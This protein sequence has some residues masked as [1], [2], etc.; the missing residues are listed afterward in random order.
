MNKL[1]CFHQDNP[2]EG[3]P[4]GFLRGLSTARLGG[5]AQ[6]I[7][8]KPKMLEQISDGNS[9]D[10]IFYLDGAHSPESMEVC[11]RWFSS[12]VG[13]A[14]QSVKN[15]FVKELGYSSLYENKDSGETKK[16]SKKVRFGYKVI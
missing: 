3:L 1:I 12:A 2:E 15:G 8:D 14:Q 16:A 9:G 11:A 6:T 13:E 5:R 10:L 7:I 4:E